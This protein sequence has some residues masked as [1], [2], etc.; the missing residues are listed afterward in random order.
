[1]RKSHCCPR[2]I[3]AM[4]LVSPPALPAVYSFFT[5]SVLQQIAVCSG[6]HGNERNSNNEI[7]SKLKHSSEP[8][9]LSPC[10]AKWLWF[11]ARARDVSVLHG[12]WRQLSSACIGYRHKTAKAWGKK[13]WSCNSTRLLIVEI[14]YLSTSQM[15][16]YLGELGWYGVHWIGLAQDREQRQWTFGFLKMLGTIEWLNNWGPLE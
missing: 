11:P 10:W 13:W 9:E 12:L 6:F 3:V 5:A 8:R 16:M 1:M 4:L 7:S 2:E 15:Y 14:C